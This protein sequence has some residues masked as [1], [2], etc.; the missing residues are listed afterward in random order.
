MAD[1]MKKC[2]RLLLKDGGLLLIYGPFRAMK[3][4]PRIRNKEFDAT[5]RSAG[6]ADL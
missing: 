6:V 5:L 2:A 1:G 4:F 3:N